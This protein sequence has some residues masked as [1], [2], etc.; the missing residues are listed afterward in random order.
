VIVPRSLLLL[1]IL[2][3]ASFA[4]R[5]QEGTPADRTGPVPV[6]VT[7]VERAT[8]AETARG[9]GTLRASDTVEL[10]AEVD[11]PLDAVH[12]EEGSTVA[13][14]KLLFTLDD[15]PLRRRRQA[16]LAA[17]RAARAR[18]QSATARVSRRRPIRSSGAVSEEDLDQAVAERREAKAEVARLRAELQVTEEQLDDT[19][20]RAPFRGRISESLVDPGDYLQVGEHLATLYR[21]RPLEVTF[22][23]PERFAGHLRR[24]QKVHVVPAGARNLAFDTTVSYVSPSV[25]ESARDLTVKSRYA[26][27]AGSQLAPGMSVHAEL[28]LQTR[29]ARPLVPAKALIGSSDGYFVF[30]VEKGTARR[31]PVRTGLREPG[32]V[33]I[34]EGLNPGMKVV[35][36]GHMD[37]TDGA[38]IRVVQARGSKERA[39]RGERR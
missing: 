25:Q 33:E 29:T 7:E 30:V 39:A 32:R 13:Q 11:G 1:P 16:R 14:G 27:S 4:C 5:A 38:A 26:P 3:G 17:I 8:I 6:R 18:A 24:G 37:L 35:L 10:Q 23:L 9:V 34:R 19:R 36:E 28:T 2:A 12:F 21:H 20:I 15:T 31:Q 22:S